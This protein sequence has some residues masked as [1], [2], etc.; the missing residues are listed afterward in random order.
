MVKVI[1]LEGPQLAAPPSISGMVKTCKDQ[2]V[3]RRV[4]GEALYQSLY[5]EA[6]RSIDPECPELA[7]LYP[8]LAFNALERARVMFYDRLTIGN[9][10]ESDTNDLRSWTR[11]LPE[12]DGVLYRKTKQLMKWSE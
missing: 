10:T 7:L 3:V 6:A 2:S 5:A 1:S 8:V 9:L 12:D 4:L 11:K